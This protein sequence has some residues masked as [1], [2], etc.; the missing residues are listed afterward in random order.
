M[1]RH[2]DEI[3]PLLL[4]KTGDG[5]SGATDQHRHVDIEIPAAGW[6]SREVHRARPGNGASSVRCS[7]RMLADGLQGRTDI[8]EQRSPELRRLEE[9]GLQHQLV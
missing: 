8:G 1:A 9:L 2:D 5:D 4:G 3:G 7:R 6:P